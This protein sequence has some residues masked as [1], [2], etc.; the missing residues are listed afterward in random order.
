MVLTVSHIVDAID[1]FRPLFIIHVL[2]SAPDDLNRILRKKESA[3]RAVGTGKEWTAMSEDL[4]GEVHPLQASPTPSSFWKGQ[5]LE[6][7]RFCFPASSSPT[8]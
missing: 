2:P 8:P 1:V 7:H 4:K 6:G 3:G 5:K